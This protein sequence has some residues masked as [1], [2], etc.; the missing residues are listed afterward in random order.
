MTMQILF[1]FL[2]GHK[3]SSLKYD[4]LTDIFAFL[5]SDN[6][7]QGNEYYIIGCQQKKEDLLKNNEKALM[8]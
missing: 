8:M 7:K 6:V 5:I 3:S 2:A 4:I 1:F